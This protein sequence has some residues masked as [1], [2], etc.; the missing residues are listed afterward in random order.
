[1]IFKLDN[2]CRYMVLH[3]TEEKFSENPLKEKIL[4]SE[5]Q[6]LRRE[7]R[8]ALITYILIPKKTSNCC[9]NYEVILYYEFLL[10]IKVLSKV[11]RSV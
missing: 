9:W 10:S 4:D 7:T 5:K 1:M 2:T 6:M 11:L 3:I 8:R